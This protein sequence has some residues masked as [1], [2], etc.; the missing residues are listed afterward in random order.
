MLH[1]GDEAMFEAMVLE[2]QSRGV[3][4]ITGVS[5]NPADS[6]SRYGIEAVHGIGFRGLDRETMVA[7]MTTVLSGTVGD[8]DPSLAVANAIRA[9]DLLVIAGGG[10]MTSI[11]P[12]HIFER[13]T[14]VALAAAAGVPVAVSGQTLGPDL[15]AQ[16]AALLSGLLDSAALVSVREADSR[17]RAHVLG[18]TARHGADDA[19]FLAELRASTTDL[20]SSPFCLVTL[21]SHTGDTD[22]A[23]LTAAVATMLDT[24]AAT[25]GL[26][27]VFSGHFAPLDGDAR[28]DEVM[29][30]LVRERMTAPSS[31][32]RVADA[33]A[34]ASLAR[35]AELVI[36][37]RYHPAVFAVSGGVPTIGIPVD[38][39]TT[40]K[41][42]GALA[43][44]GQHSFVP[45]SELVEAGAASLVHSVWHDRE[46]IRA[47]AISAA[48]RHLAETKEWWDAVTALGNR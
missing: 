7:R 22:R 12:S 3:T 1:V 43:N 33:A 28:G 13:A 29:H 10:N 37:S 26:D 45:A 6:A 25:T 9:A 42:R 5:S 2:L 20:P 47:S 32:V 44:F 23:A 19:S 16:D 15:T 4:E 36:T 48:R 41:L 18:T 46:A 30:E 38:A 17:A 27:I 24:V 14:L 8:G 40:I 35:A 11:W 34:S 31:R 39:Y 21:S